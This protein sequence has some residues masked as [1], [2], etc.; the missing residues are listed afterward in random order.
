MASVIPLERE[1]YTC[2]EVETLTGL[3]HSGVWRAAVRGDLPSIRVGR[4]ILFPRRAIEEL[5]AQASSRPS[6]IGAGCDAEE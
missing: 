1:F 2:R 6:P 4:R 5:I 3:S